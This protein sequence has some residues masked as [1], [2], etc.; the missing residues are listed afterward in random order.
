MPPPPGASP[1]ALMK[2]EGSGRRCLNSP[3]SAP[4]AQQRARASDGIE[5][6]GSV[7][8]PLWREYSAKGAIKEAREAPAATT[9]QE[10]APIAPPHV[11]GQRSDSMDSA[12]MVESL[13]DEDLERRRESSPAVRRSHA[14]SSAGTPPSAPSR[15]RRS[16]K[17]VMQGPV[18]SS[19]SE[20]PLG[21]LMAE[22]KAHAQTKHDLAVALSEREEEE[23]GRKTAE[24]RAMAVA[25]AAESAAEAAGAAEQATSRAAEEG[26]RLK[27]S[28]IAQ[29]VATLAA[30]RERDA[31]EV[32]KLAAV[33]E[34]D[35]LE[36]AK[37]AAVQERD[38]LEV[39]N[40]AAVRDRDAFEATQ[41]AAV[42][43]RDAFEATQL[44]AVR[45]RDAFEANVGQL[46][47]AVGRLDA[48][49]T[50]AR[51]SVRLAEEAASQAR[52]EAREAQKEARDAQKDAR[53]A[54]KQ[55]RDAE[56][57]ARDAQKDARDAH[58]DASRATMSVNA[59]RAEVSAME[60]Q[61]ARSGASSAEWMTAFKKL[62][63]Q[64]GPW[65][66][67]TG[68]STA[69]DS[70][71]LDPR[72]ELTEATGLP[73]DGVGAA[74]PLAL[75]APAKPSDNGG[76]LESPPPRPREVRTPWIVW[77]AGA[78]V[79]VAC[80]VTLSASSHQQLA[81]P[82]QGSGAASIEPL[83]AANARQKPAS[84]K[85]GD[86]GVDGGDKA[87][88][89]IRIGRPKREKK[90]KA[91][92]RA[93]GDAEGDAPPPSTDASKAEGYAELV[94]DLLRK[95][96]LPS[97]PA[98]L[99]LAVCTWAGAATLLGQT[100]VWRFPRL[101]GAMVMLGMQEVAETLAVAL[102]G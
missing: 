78:M 26:E 54:Q 73:S 82:Q 93:E 15:A 13:F 70:P 85:G 43:E 41:L 40:L 20:W 42:R 67:P 27:A 7:R 80:Q 92:S 6:S 52:A 34:R 99:A 49:V 39:A 36:V 5:P 61:L 63:S 57:D 22:R 46:E 90:A 29:R 79:I 2:R 32:D 101:G 14:A 83:R 65:P 53:D 31:F 86:K 68:G 18:T 37:L 98:Q 4:G 89:K 55:A 1:Q 19:D 72:A 95:V 30:T 69:A 94:G 38:A 21:Q 28:L 84:A 62:S 100:E 60:K 12:L 97:A 96:G 74:K 51:M 11:V 58:K 47:A 50:D 77:L 66:S 8:R 75:A 45:E 24:I 17:E 10:T 76:V 9:S 16:S 87:E 56:K 64:I 81:T 71:P 35:A 59:L 44:A 102:A 23:Q 3:H 48:E 88:H 25:H 33:Q 91:K